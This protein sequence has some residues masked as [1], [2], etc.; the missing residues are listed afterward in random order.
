M[1]MHTLA[2]I[3][4]RAGSK[5]LPEKCVHPILGRPMIEYTFDH[6]LCAQTIDAIVL[7][8]DSRPAK[9]LAIRYGIHVIDRPAH[10]ACD[11][12]TIYS[13]ARHAVLAYENRGGLHPGIVVVLYANI[14]VRDRTIIDRA[15]VHL[16][17][18]KADSVR[19][20]AAVGKHHPDWLH[21]VDGDRMTQFREN[22]VYRRQDLDPLY[23][24]DAAVVAVTRNAL[25]TD[26]GHPDD[27]FAFLGDD[28]RCIVQNS[29][30]AVDV[31]DIR[32]VYVAEAILR[33]QRAGA[34]HLSP[35]EPMRLVTAPV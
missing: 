24:H 10:L 1:C 18:T 22:N 26:P 8:T 5:S 4:A 27:H 12:A 15:V 20:V 6:A 32:D 30:D 34:T 29:C 11:T 33:S 2:V 17:E 14:P 21:R 3:L 35:V 13:A 16:E 7:S 23:Y 19:T 31:D 9:D 28:R 25:F